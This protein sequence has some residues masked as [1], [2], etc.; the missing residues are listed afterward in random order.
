AQSSVQIG[1][2]VDV[3]AGSLKRSGD[4]ASTSVVNSS[5]MQT[6]WW[7]FKGT[8]DLG[9]GLQANFALT[10]FF[11]PDIGGTGRNNSDT[12]FSRDANVGL[13]GSFGRVSVGRDLAPNFIPTLKLSPFGGSFVFAPLELHTQTPSGSYRGQAWSP[14]V[15]GD[16]GWSNEIMYVT[17]Q[18]GGFTTSLFYQFGEQADNSGKNNFG[19]NT[20]YEQGPLTFGAYFQSVEVNNPLDSIA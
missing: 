20:M 3:Y 6:S 16:T 17:P 1:G 15:A 18:I 9:N 13:S 11:R 7:G 19:V 12:M 10:G 2:M 5:G 8:E 14:T 4:A